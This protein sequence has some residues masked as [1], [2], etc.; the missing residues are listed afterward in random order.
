MRGD[1]RLFFLVFIIMTALLFNPRAGI[2]ALVVNLITTIIVAILIFSGHY[3]LSSKATVAGDIG[4][5]IV[6]NLSLILLTTV[7]LTALT[8]LVKEFDNSQDHLHKALEYL[9]DSTSFIGTDI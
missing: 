8:L 2:L 3:T 5:W 6:S 9:R 1:A 4:L 7:S